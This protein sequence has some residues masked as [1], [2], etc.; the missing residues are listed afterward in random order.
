MWLTVGKVGAIQIEFWHFHNGVNHL[1]D[2]LVA[3]AEAHCMAHRLAS[4]DGDA[5]PIIR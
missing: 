5:A 1:H 2:A 4:F 3:S